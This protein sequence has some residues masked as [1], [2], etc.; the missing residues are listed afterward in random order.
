M[1][2]A[3]C[4]YLVDVFRAGGASL[5]GRSGPGEASVQRSQEKAR[6][7]AQDLQQLVNHFCLQFLA[8]SSSAP[9]APA[10]GPAATHSMHMEQKLW[11]SKEHVFL[12]HACTTGQGAA[13]SWHRC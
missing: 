9:E 1:V 8:C 5:P 6:T 7:S 3:M 4:R 2:P 10:S 11:E 13:T 12:G